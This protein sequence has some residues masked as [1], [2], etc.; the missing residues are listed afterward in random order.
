LSPAM[1]Q[2]DQ[3]SSNDHFRRAW[4]GNSTSQPAATKEFSINMQESLEA[5]RIWTSIARPLVSR[6]PARN[7]E[8]NKT[9]ASC[10]VGASKIVLDQ[11]LSL[12]PC[13]ISIEDVEAELMQ[14]IG[15]TKHDLATYT[16]Q[17]CSSQGEQRCAQISLCTSQHPDD[18]WL[19]EAG[20]WETAYYGSSADPAAIRSIA[21]HGFKRICD[22]FVEN[23][24]SVRAEAI[25]CSPDL[26]YV[27][28]YARG[29][30]EINEDSDE[31]FVLFLCKV[32]PGSFDVVF[33]KLWVVPNPNDIRPCAILWRHI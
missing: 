15:L 21:R 14:L 31:K 19:K 18:G 16:H 13:S 9:V 26:N 1:V 3:S 10:A 7:L 12:K 5:R 32:R 27:R 30:S 2:T 4:V 17:W 8:S 24:S 20:G 29:A 25:H 22:D 33:G 28:S 11:N 6:R 23:A